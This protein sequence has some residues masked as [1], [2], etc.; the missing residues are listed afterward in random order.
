MALSTKSGERADEPRVDESLRARNEIL[1]T[2]PAAFRAFFPTSVGAFACSSSGEAIDLDV[3]RAEFVQGKRSLLIDSAAGEAMYLTGTASSSTED[4]MGDT[5]DDNCQASM[6]AQAKNMTQFL[7]H[8]YTIPESILGTIH[9][10]SI[11]RASDPKLGDCLDFEI[12]SSV[13]D[14]NPRAVKCWQ[15]VQGGIKLG[16]SIGGIFTDVD[17]KDPDDWFSGLTVHDIELL[18]VSLVGIPAN[19]RTYTKGVGFVA[20]MTKGL[21]ANMAQVA[22]SLDPQRRATAQVRSMVRKSLLGGIRPEDIR[23]NTKQT[24]TREDAND[25]HSGNTV[26]ENPNATPS[27]DRPVKPEDSPTAGA[28][29]VGPPN[30]DEPPAVPQVG[31]SYVT[32][33]GQPSESNPVSPEN[34]APK[35][36]R[37]HDEADND[38]HQG[39]PDQLPPRQEQHAQQ[40]AP[41]APSGAEVLASESAGQAKPA[42]APPASA[43]ASA[44]AAAPPAAPTKSLKS[45]KG[46]DDSDDAAAIIPDG[47]A[48]D[49]LRR[50]A[51]KSMRAIKRALAPGMHKESMDHLRKAHSAV[52]SMVGPDYDLPDDAML[53]DGPDAAMR[54][55]NGLAAKSADLDAE[56][57]KKI[58]QIAVVDAALAKKVGE[59]SVLTE[60][61]AELRATPTG[62]RSVVSGGSI[63]TESEPLVP[64]EAYYKSTHEQLAAVNH[65]ITSRGTSARDRA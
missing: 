15:A 25:D 45:I 52:K 43:P 32:G 34:A 20:E 6:L 22:D 44:P 8:V 26:P 9:E 59:E 48:G 18:E 4:R 40:G 37:L 55:V 28:S 11:R 64:N 53:D 27:R 47:D 39:G 2:H 42:G 36:A 5:L 50:K 41:D 17:L 33:V 38:G 29:S 60:K 65:E 24:G 30:A 54:A 16:W 61:L 3:R 57:A 10:A 12:V 23:L 62:R 1:A 49:R 13:W 7:D 14:G 58:A 19:R 46:L 35:P 63:Q 21:R 56:I 31:T 51:V